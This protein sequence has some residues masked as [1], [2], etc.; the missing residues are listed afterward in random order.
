VWPTAPGAQQMMIHLDIA[1]DDLVEGVAHATRLGA[2]AAAH[3]PQE[4]V[5]VMLDPAGRPFCLFEGPV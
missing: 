5:R 3:Q 2:R 4:D 1:V